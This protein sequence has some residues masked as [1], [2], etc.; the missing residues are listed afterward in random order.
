MLSVQQFDLNERC[1]E[2]YFFHFDPIP[3][4]PE[5]NTMKKKINCPDIPDV[6]VIT[7]NTCTVSEVDTTIAIDTVVDNVKQKRQISGITKLPL[8]QSAK[9]KTLSPALFYSCFTNIG[10]RVLH[11]K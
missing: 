8:R 2:E 10:K 7:C 1:P 3:E 4:Y 6:K 11:S 9:T 5:R